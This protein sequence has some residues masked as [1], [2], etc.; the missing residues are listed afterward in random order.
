MCCR[1]KES[2]AFAY[3][4]PL[5][6]LTLLTRTFIHPL[7]ASALILDV[8]KANSQLYTLLLRNVMRDVRGQHHKYSQNPCCNSYMNFRLQS[9]DYSNKK[10]GT[11]W[12]ISFDR[13]PTMH[14][15]A[16]QVQRLHILSKLC[17]RLFSSDHPCT[18]T[19]STPA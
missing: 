15:R 6:N 4:A 9:A 8:C 3:A 2:V 17:R 19:V 14:R 13:P 18:W 5:I 7:L 1:E 11:A 12:Q 10:L 16:V